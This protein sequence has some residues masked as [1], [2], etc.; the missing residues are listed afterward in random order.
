VEV[1]VE[2]EQG[3][4]SS[5]RETNAQGEVEI[6]REWILDPACTAKFVV[7]SMEPQIDAGP[8][9]PNSPL[10]CVKLPVPQNLDRLI[11]VVVPA[12]PLNL[13]LTFK[14]PLASGS[15][16][17]VSLQPV[18]DG[19][20]LSLF[21]FRPAQFRAPPLPNLT[22]SALQPGTYNVS[23]DAPGL[24]TW[25]SKVTVPLSGVVVAATLERGADVTFALQ[26][27]GAKNA[28]VPCKVLH[29]GSEVV[30]RSFATSPL[31]GLP[32]G[33]YT[34]RVPSS[35]EL[36]Q[37][38]ADPESSEFNLDPQPAYLGIDVDFEIGDQSPV[39]IDLGKIELPQG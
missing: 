3:R 6:D 20:D 28:Y 11:P 38:R 1:A 16:V 4:I 23:V 34:L 26:I 24:C 39:V 33:R 17:I 18:R 32:K 35:A 10:F 31:R 7:F 13:T 19:N 21:G 30:V 22:F 25:T 2:G 5:T 9:S 15:Q 29:K 37:R 8:S 36:Q 27:P 14:A 12:A